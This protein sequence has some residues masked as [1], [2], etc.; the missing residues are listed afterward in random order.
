MSS[1]PYYLD[2]LTSD[3][4]EESYHKLLREP[5][6]TGRKRTSATANRYPHQPQRLLRLWEEAAQVDRP[7][8]RGGSEEGKG[9]QGK[10]PLPV[11]PRGW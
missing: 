4:V 7:Q 9:A 8:P 1:A 11:A 3:Q 5:G 6:E 10:G 2:N